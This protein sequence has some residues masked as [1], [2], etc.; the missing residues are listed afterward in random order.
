M[1]NGDF[2]SIKEKIKSLQIPILRDN[3]SNILIYFLLDFFFLVKLG[4]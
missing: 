2:L 4:S 3:H 1:E